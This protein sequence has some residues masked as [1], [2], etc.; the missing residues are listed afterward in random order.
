MNMK[1]YLT[2]KLGIPFKLTPELVGYDGVVQARLKECEITDMIVDLIDTWSIKMKVPYYII[3]EINKNK[4]LN[5]NYDLVT[6]E[7]QIRLK[8]ND[9]YAVF[10]VK[11][12]EENDD[13][14]FKEITAFS[15]ER[16][17]GKEIYMDKMERQ[18]KKDA[19]ETGDGIFDIMEQQLRGWKL[20]Y[21]DELAKIEQV[22][23][24][25]ANKYRFFDGVQAKWC[26]FLKN[27][28]PEAYDVLLLYDTYSKEIYCYDYKAYG[29]DTGFVISKKNIINEIGKITDTKELVTKLYATGKSKKEDGI[30]TME[31]ACPYGDFVLNYDG[32]K[33]LMSDSLRTATTLY[34]TRINELFNQW[35]ALYTQTLPLIADVS[36]LEAQ[37]LQLD[38]R[39]KQM[40]SQQ[41]ILIHPEENANPAD[42]SETKTKKDGYI[43]QKNTIKATL[44]SKQ[45]QLTNL[46]TQ[47]RNISISMQPENITYNGNKI[48]NNALLDELEAYTK[49]DR[50]ENEFCFKAESLY[51]WATKK[52][53][54]LSKPEISFT[55]KADNF[56]DD[57]MR[58]YND[59]NQEI[60][61]GDWF[62]LR[63]DKFKEA[64]VRF[65]G[66][67]YNPSQKELTLKFSNR[68]KRNEF[69]G[70]SKS[71]KSAN[72]TTGVV[73]Q[74]KIN[75]DL[76][77]Q[78]TDFVRAIREEGLD[79]SKAMIFSEHNRNK[80]EITEDGEWFTN[81][82]N[83]N[84]MLVITANAIV[85]SDDGLNSVKTCMTS[86]GLIGDTIIGRILAGENLYISNKNNNFII[87]QNG[88][89]IDVERLIIRS[90]NGDKTV[91][92]MIDFSANQLTTAFTNLNTQTNSR[93][94][95]TD[96]RIT[97]EVN[98]LRNDTHTQINQLD[99][100][101]SLKASK[102]DLISEINICPENIVISSDRLDLQGLVTFHNLTDGTT[103]I[104]GDNI[105]TGTINC[106]L[107]NGGT[108]NGQYIHGGTINGAHIEGVTF[109]GSELNVGDI[110]CQQLNVRGRA[111]L[112][113]DLVVND[114]FNADY[115]GSYGNMS[116]QG[117]FTCGSLVV[118]DGN[119]NC[120]QRTK[121]YG[122]VLINAYETAEVYFG[123]L[124]FGT[125][126]DGIYVVKIDP[127]ML[128]CFNTELPYHVF[129]QT[130]NGTNLKINRYPSYIVF[131]GE[132]GTE[133]SYEI[134]AKRRGQE[135]TRLEE[136]KVKDN[137]E[138]YVK[139]IK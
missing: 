113:Q 81:A 49:E 5:A 101:I 83:E 102:A 87:D 76:A 31:N 58:R 91:S 118:Q 62:T 24:I 116:C 35:K 88:M 111:R 8:L 132:E 77:S 114:D 121:N 28:V 7:K 46:Q 48:F 137:R 131:K 98:N 25:R 20:A 104:S 89:R 23:G 123:D 96:N 21:I 2:L 9:S 43:S 74:K 41:A 133:F 65:I 61:I 80:I 124:G 139:K 75:W 14:Y 52:V 55:I 1:D 11:E 34:D 33:D 32:V 10:V 71:I 66:Y 119:K 60:S 103:T 100:R 54:D 128:E 73:R 30:I 78:Q 70:V 27:T 19:L 37:I 93:I 53:A 138:T 84:E 115:V 44:T 22:N 50:L 97:S 38:T 68:D 125:I 67:T 106:N 4:I 40:Q 120:M 16:N 72:K 42:I 86:Q 63:D 117:T 69:K 3:D 85:I 94:T 64:T 136:F 126:K 95:Q 129:T 17:I 15:L 107:L 13:G 6:F 51:D 45:S 105:T 109:D 108:I 90:S 56:L 112:R 110:D 92:G 99:D 47:M 39:I 79:T 12:I 29:Q 82:Y 134:K 36:N 59:F 130:Y 135:N 18:L 127:V 57:L 122:N 26:D